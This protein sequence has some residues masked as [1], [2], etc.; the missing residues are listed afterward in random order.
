MLLE[1]LEQ[2]IPG[3]ILK[4]PLGKA[5][6]AALFATI[7]GLVE[8]ARDATNAAR[9]GQ[10]DGDG[11]DLGGF[12]DV[13]A[14]PLIG[15]DRGIVQGTVE[16]FGDYASRLRKWRAIR[17]AAGT[18]W[19]LLSQVQAI[20]GPVRVRLVSDHGHWWTI[21][22]DGTLRYHT[23]T[24]AGAFEQ[25][26]DGHATA[27]TTPA[28]PWDWDGA[29]AQGDTWLVIYCHDLVAGVVFG[30]GAVYGASGPDTVDWG[31]GA[32]WGIDIG[33]RGGEWLGKLR[34]TLRNNEAC[35]AHLRH[36]IFTFD[37]GSFDPET[38]GPYPAAGM[39]DGTWGLPWTTSA[40][41]SV[42]SRP[43]IARYWNPES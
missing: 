35:G 26:T 6:F 2:V 5:V 36:V 29:S 38:L 43:A 41:I 9:P 14:L 8:L 13:D 23:P 19:G 16:S 39:P 22:A 33:P 1:R 27:I 11:P 20:T 30:D 17:A 18:N 15:R 34:Q 12:P 21:E 42:P 24:A 10:V 32:R 25:T 3:R 37:D 28:H 40:G 7:D 4:S 31:T